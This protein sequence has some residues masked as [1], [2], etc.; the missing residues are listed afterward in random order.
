M[1]TVP[2]TPSTR[3]TTWGWLSRM[4]MQ[5]VIAHGARSPCRIRSRGPGSPCGSGVASP[6]CSLD[7]RREPAARIRATRHRGGGR[8]TTGSR[9]GAGRASRSIRCCPRWRPCAGRRSR[10]SPRCAASWPHSALFSVTYSAAHCLGAHRCLSRLGQ[11]HPCQDAGRGQGIAH[12]GVHGGSGED[13]PDDL[14][15]GNHHGPT[16]ISRAYVGVE[17][18]R[19]HGSP[20]PGCRCRARGGDLS[21]DAGPADGQRT[22]LGVTQDRRLGA[23]GGPGRDRCARTGP[24]GA[25]VRRTARS[26]FGIE[27]HDRGAV[28]SSATTTWVAVSPATTWAFVA[29]SPWP[30]TKPEPSCSSPHA[31][32]EDLDGR[33][34]RRL[35][36]GSGSPRLVGVATAPG[37]GW[38]KVEKTWGNPGSLR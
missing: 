22:V 16:R 6:R 3:R 24:S 33:R 15:A 27:Q 20:P 13:D 1:S 37:E 35:G 38:V 11:L 26:N 30:T 10:H 14:P 34:D 28:R 2:D 23:R 17:C 4:G 18:S 5:S 8:S 31:A 12:V 32:P 21:R 29:T 19:R 36:Q 7:P 25:P 9:S